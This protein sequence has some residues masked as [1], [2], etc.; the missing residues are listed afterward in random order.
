M[1]G[2]SLRSSASINR[3]QEDVPALGENTLSTNT[4]EERATHPLNC[5]AP[6]NT[7]TL[8]LFSFL[9][10]PRLCSSSHFVFATARSLRFIYATQSHT[11][12]TPSLL[13]PIPAQLLRLLSAL[14]NSRSVINKNPDVSDF[15]FPSPSSSDGNWLSS[16]DTASSVAL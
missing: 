6:P 10:P 12:R 14:K 7:Q 8:P 15:S 2:T 16:E 9:S 11:L 13:F 5:P 4:N 3:S 1:K